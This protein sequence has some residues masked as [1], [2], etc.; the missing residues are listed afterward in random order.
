MGSISKKIVFVTGNAKKLEEAIAILGSSL[1]IESRKIDLPELQGDPIEISKEK[2]RI[3]AKE[4]NGPVLIEDTCLCYN[5]LKGLPGPYIKW[6]LDS[7]KP[8][9][10]Y[11]LLAGFEDKSAYALCNFAYSEGPGFEPIVFEGRTNGKIVPPRGPRDFGWDP[12]FQP[13]GFEQTYAE[14]DKS[15]KNTISHRTRSLQLVKQFLNE[16][17]YS[18]STVFDK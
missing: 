18:A 3:A 15:L 10:L 17:G 4:I 11:T 7:I 16:K 6:F 14:M 1:P 13:D 9:G 5:A 8:E 12:V 2:C